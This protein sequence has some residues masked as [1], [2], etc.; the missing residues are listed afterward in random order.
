MVVCGKDY[1]KKGSLLESGIDLY[2]W[3]SYD[4]L[5]DVEY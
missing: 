2:S 1:Q 4:V 5:V 3:H